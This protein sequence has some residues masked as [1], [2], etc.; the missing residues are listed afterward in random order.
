MRIA[1]I[2][3]G[4]VGVTTAYELTL[5]GHEVHVF[6]RCSSVAA[7][8]SFANAGV[9]APGYVAPL[10]APGLPSLLLRQ[11]L[12]G[13]PALRLRPGASKA[14]WRWLWRGWRAC[15]EPDYRTNRTALV[16]LAQLSQ[17]RLAEIT[18]Q[19]PLDFEQASGLLVLLRDDPTLK[20]AQSSLP[21]LREL[22]IEVQE[23]SAAD[24]QT[25]EPALQLSTPLAGVWRLPHSQVGNCRQVAHLLKEAAEARGASFHFGVEVL[26][27]AGGARPGLT[28][29]PSTQADRASALSLSPA[30]RGGVGDS[31]LEPREHRFDAVVLCAGADSARLL[32]TVG[33][34][35]PL[36]P[37]FG[38]AISA[39]VRHPERAPV[40][41]VIDERHKVTISR[42]GNRVRVAGCAELGGDIDH[43]RPAAIATLHRVLNDWFPG[44]AQ[45]SQLQVWK[46]ARPML[47]DGPPLIG[48]G[49]QPGLWLN[50]GHGASGWALSCGSART[51][52]DLI[53]QRDPA[54]ETDRFR[55]GRW[56]D[57]LGASN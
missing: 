28:T 14:A 42:L 45:L 34:R 5:D 33:M 1:V 9:I 56:R 24:A 51:I 39:P 10:A 18:R 46:G 35:L 13:Q 26:S 3:A 23:L 53:A 52:A 31:T 57:N 43:H 44:A 25:H 17:Q 47:P 15:Q 50:L 36:Q 12:Q 19:L 38:Y 4:I 27:V 20:H 29:R 55:L 49:P 16:H 41:A 40:S 54:I 22:G 21:L 6:D 37:I 11:M 8:T 32:A 30:S 2:G 48:S 7:E